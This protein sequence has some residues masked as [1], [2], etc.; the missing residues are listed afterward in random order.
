M[1]HTS[2]WISIEEERPPARVEVIVMHEKGEVRRSQYMGHGYGF[3]LENLYGKVIW[4][5][6]KSELP[7]RG[8]VKREN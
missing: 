3:F 8:E 5:M 7:P 2:E 1:R 4:W 6:P